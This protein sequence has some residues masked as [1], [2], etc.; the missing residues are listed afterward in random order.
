MA[1]KEPV[2]AV[3]WSTA[4][5]VWPTSIPRAV[6][7]STSTKT[8]YEQ[9]PSRVDQGSGEKRDRIVLTLI[10]S[11]SVVNDVF[12]A[13]GQ[14][15]DKFLVERANCGRRIVVV[16]DPNHCLIFALAVLE[17]LL[18]CC[19]FQLLKSQV[20]LPTSCT[21][22]R[23]EACQRTDEDFC[24]RS[25]L[26]LL[27]SFD[28]THPKR[29]VGSQWSASR[30][31]AVKKGNRGLTAYEDFG[32]HHRRS[33]QHVDSVIAYLVSTTGPLPPMSVQ[34]LGNAAPG[35]GPKSAAYECNSAVPIPIQ[36]GQVLLIPDM[37]QVYRMGA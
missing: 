2:V 10:V 23:G 13:G 30:S 29:R 12:D 19:R 20:E 26:G 7:A 22:R 21:P 16:E 35:R 34:V 6:H 14:C 5:G 3:A 17:K 24:H 1:R 31:H 37:T 33:R 25:E 4:L 9:R 32:H 27:L 28:P 36:D 15:V 18:A 11:S 8:Q